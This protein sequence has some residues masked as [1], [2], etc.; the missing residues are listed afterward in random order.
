MLHV[1]HLNVAYD[2]LQVLWDVSLEVHEGEIVALIGSNGAG[3]TT[4]L[5]TISG[6]MKP[7]SGAIRFRAKRSPVFPRTTSADAV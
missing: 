7:L 6:L 4:L 2:T 3:K 5:K 1:E